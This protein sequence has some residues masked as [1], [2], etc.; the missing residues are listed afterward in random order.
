MLDCGHFIFSETSTL[1]KAISLAYYD[2]IDDLPLIN[3][4]VELYQAISAESLN[5][6][7]N[8][9]FQPNKVSELVYSPRVD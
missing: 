3:T 7:A 1:N 4:E 8:L 9:L 5:Q 2:Y 6:Y